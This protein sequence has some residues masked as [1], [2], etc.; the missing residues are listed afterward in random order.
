MAHTACEGM[1]LATRKLGPLERQKRLWGVLLLL[2]LLS[3]LLVFY[4]IPLWQSVFY[5]FTDLGSFG[6]WNTFT[7]DNYLRLTEDPELWQALKN[8]LIYTVVCAPLIVVISLL[9]ALGLNAKVRGVGV[10]RT[11]LFLP[12]VT[13]SAAVAMVWKWIFNLDFGLLN[14]ILAHYGQPAVAWLSDPDVVR[15]SVMIVVIWS[16]IALKMVILLAG[17]QAVPEQLMEAAFIDGAGPIRRFFSVTLPMLVPTL[18]FVTIITMIEI[19]QIFDLI[20]M[21]IG[22]A[23]IAEEEAMTVVYL[24]Y[25]YAFDYQEKGYASALTM[26][27]FAIT[28][29]LTVVQLKINKRLTRWQEH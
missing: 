22:S 15:I 7:F 26:V 9:F 28:M 12:A 4:F 1:T 5:S 14:Q 3:G 23:S 8:T 13:M 6:K 17:L 19:L 16:S 2:P 25:K 29:L 11:L 18:F 21:M 24:F 10:Y 20:F 27:L